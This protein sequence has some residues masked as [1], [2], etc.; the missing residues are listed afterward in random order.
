MKNYKKILLGLFSSLVFCSFASAASMRDYVCIVRS[1]YS[2]S[3]KAFLTQ[4]KNT[5]A[6]QGYKSLADSI[7]KYLKGTFGSGFV[8]TGSNGRNYIITNRHVVTT[9][10]TVN[11]QFENE[12]GSMSEYKD[13]KILGVDEDLDIAVIELPSSVKKTGLTFRTA[14]VNDADQVWSAGFP[15]LG[16]EP[17]WQ[18]G[19]GV[20]T[21]S[22]AR[23]KELVDPSIS[24][25]IQHSA[26]V[27]G[28]NS[29]GPLLVTDSKAKGG[30]AVVGIN[31]W[32]AVNR[33]N[34][35]YAIPAAAV[36]TSIEKIITSKGVNKTIT[37]RI[38]QFNNS[39]AN[40]EETFSSMSKYISNEMVSNL[41]G[42]AFTKILSKAT[43]SAYET[44]IA[45]FA[46]DPIE[47]VRYGLAYYI[48]TK[49]RKNDNVIDYKA[50]A[51][52]VSGNGQKVVFTISEKNQISSF[53]IVEQGRWRLT[54]FD[55]II[56]KGD[57]NG[58]GSISFGDP[59]AFYVGGGAVFNSYKK[60][61]IIDAGINVSNMAIELNVRN[62]YPGYKTSVCFG[63]RYFLP[64]NFGKFIIEPSAGVL[65]GLFK[66]ESTSEFGSS[67]PDIKF[68]LPIGLDFA[69][70]VSDNFAISVGGKYDILNF[71]DITSSNNS[72]ISSFGVT[73]G[74]KFGRTTG[75]SLW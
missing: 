4:Y 2:E 10:E 47:G 14:K 13:L 38:E 44:I 16:G 52:E 49:F 6:S 58:S 66:S 20:V 45:T 12:D 23:L 15:G 40:K 9:A 28:G 46:N 51:P 25:L 8:Y 70:C 55:D 62:D 32:K 18:L 48:W 36:K 54:D 39:I 72:K 24:T 68:M 11:I 43:R 21:N 1:N 5:M 50:E 17:V 73:A 69:F 34:T 33:E 42:P 7:E 35:N 64:I 59:F 56:A 60:G 31:T 37:E 22:V 71:I 61:F 53:W 57:V 74:I 67:M 27:D 3:N 63:T 19:N 29:G 65:V 75:F 30:Y 41:K 26:Q